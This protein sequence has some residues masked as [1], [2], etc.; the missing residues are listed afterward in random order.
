MDRRQ[1]RNDK[2]IAA[3]RLDHVKHRDRSGAP[4]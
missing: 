1:M 2:S 4:T 3:G